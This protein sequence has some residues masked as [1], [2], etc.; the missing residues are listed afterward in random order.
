V[1]TASKMLRQ[2]SV[3]RIYVDGDSAIALF[4]AEENERD[5]KPFATYAEST[6]AWDVRG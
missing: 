3:P 1:V 2:P 6:L 4:A 5:G